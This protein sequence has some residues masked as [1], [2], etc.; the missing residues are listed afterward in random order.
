[1]FPTSLLVLCKNTIWL[2]LETSVQ[3]NQAMA[4]T[5][6]FVIMWNIFFQQSEY[7]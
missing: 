6:V 3:V 5:Y 4:Y 1:M 7:I 2:L